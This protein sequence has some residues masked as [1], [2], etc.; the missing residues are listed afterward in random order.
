[1]MKK[2]LLFIIPAFLFFYYGCNM[3]VPRYDDLNFGDTVAIAIGETLYESDSL[4]VRLDSIS[5][6]SRC[7][8]GAMCVWEG[9]ALA[10]F[11]F[12]N[13]FDTTESLVF[14]TFRR[15]SSRIRQFLLTQSA[16]ERHMYEFNMIG[17]QPYPVAGQTIRERD[18]RVYFTLT[19]EA[20]ELVRKPNIYLYPE[21]KSRMDVYLSFPHGGQVVKSAPSYPAEWKDIRVTP[22]GMID[23]TYE[24]LFYEASLPDHWQYSEGRV[25]RREHLPLFFTADM[26][27]YGFELH[28]I[29]DFLEY[30]IPR[31]KDAPYYA[32]YPQHT[33]MVN[34]AVKLHL[35]ERPDNILRLFYIIDEVQGHFELIEP[36]IPLFN[37][38]G[39]TVAE[40]G[41]IV[42]PGG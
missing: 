22:E 42:N 14:S 38:E 7:P 40:W 34:Q 6:D 26:E 29:N 16:S 39:F 13:D 31:L 4:W 30:W 10:W 37:R 27:K 9:R 21:K 28:E 5:E 35:S 8:E 25:L 12:G 1:M 33:A 36:D 20:H 41:V 2:L 23:N 24:Y 15:D 18:Y 19:V 11:T 3:F 17:V 32:I